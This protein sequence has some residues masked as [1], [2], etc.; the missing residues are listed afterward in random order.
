MGLGP[1]QPITE[2][3]RRWRL[4]AALAAV[5]L[6]LQLSGPAADGLFAFAPDAVARGEVW[7]LVSGHLQHL[8]WP[9]F[10]LNVTALG[11]IW[12]LVGS[13][14]STAQWLLV[15]AVSLAAIDVGLWV[16]LP[17]LV[18]YVGLSGVL[19]GVFAAGAVAHLRRNRI[20]AAVL[21]SLLALKLGYEFA[22][23]P[24]PGSET[25]AGGRV[26][27]EAHLFGALGGAAA[28][29][30]ARPWRGERASD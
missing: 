22:V 24:L 1:A 4:P 15:L 11:L 6:L 17:D 25:T 14:Y 3:L 2:S 18:W 30:I 19:H 12:L 21:L 8:G 5:S 20:E 26:I 28:A 10:A 29:A 9:H 7:R 16:G 27:T 23:G 13:G